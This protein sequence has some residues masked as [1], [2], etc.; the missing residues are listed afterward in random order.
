MKHSNR[1]SLPLL[2]IVA[3]AAALLVLAVPVHAQQSGAKQQQIKLQK[4]TWW[5]SVGDRVEVVVKEQLSTRTLTA[6]VT[7]IDADKGIITVDAEVD[8]KKLVRPLFASNIVSMKTVGASAAGA[9]ASG[10]AGKAGGAVPAGKASG[11]AGA[12]SPG[13]PSGK[14]DAQGYQLDENG[15]YR[16]AP[17]KGVFVLPLSGMVGKTMRGDEIDKMLAEVDK[18]GPGQ[19]VILDIDSGGGLVTEI[20]KIVDAIKRLKKDHRVVAWIRRAFSAAAC[21]SMQCEEI[22]FRTTASNGAST[23]IQQGENGMVTSSL[24]EIE[25]F[26]RDMAAI[27]EDNGYSRYIFLAMVLR[28]DVLTYTKDPVTGKVKWN[29]KITGEPG[30]VVLSDESENLAF[31]ASTALDSG[32][33][34]G[35]ADTEEELA[36]LLGL[37][38][39]YLISDCGARISGDWKKRFEGCE[40]DLEYQKG[41]AALP[42]TGTAAAQIAEQIDILQKMLSWAKRCPPCFEFAFG[43]KDAASKE[44]TKQLKDLQK[45]LRSLREES[46]K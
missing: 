3:L 27:V 28:E 42:P 10:G 23:M 31:T 37:P 14:V 38:E 26:K 16:V 7:K 6:T 30:E 40:E 21:T 5:G 33:S 46:A 35:T 15:K 8:G 39:W 9:P 34:K 17:Q 44:M 18:W 20:Y 19:T 45:Q 13:K 32:F 4:G 24:E 11:T 25:K 1:R 12:P 43:D 36:K 41:R 2:V 22:Y 29:N